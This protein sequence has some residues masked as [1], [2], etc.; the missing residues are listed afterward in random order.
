MRGQPAANSCAINA[1]CELWCWGSNEY[2]QLG[3][4]KGPPSA[5]PLHV[6]WPTP[7]KLAAGGFDFMCAIGDD[8]LVRCIGRA[9]CAQTGQGKSNAP[10]P[11]AKLVPL[12]TKA[13][14][15]DANMGEV[16]AAL[17]DGSMW[18]W[19]GA[20]CAING[21]QL[22]ARA[23]TPMIVIPLS[24]DKVVDVALGTGRV[25]V[26]RSSGKVACA[27]GFD[28]LY[29]EDVL[30]DDAEEYASGDYHQ[31][32]VRPGGTV[33][34]RG[35]N[36][37]GQVGDGTQQDQPDWQT[38]VTAGNVPL[39]SAT[40]ASAGFRGSC[41]VAAGGLLCW[42]D[43]GT[44]GTT[45]WTAQPVDLAGHKAKDVR[46]LWGHTCVLLDDDSVACAGSNYDL[47]SGHQGSGD[48]TFHPIPI[49]Q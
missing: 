47:E 15:I 11:S 42:G 27:G 34:C 46:V 1:K 22:P 32:Q 40:R 23:A 14:A 4:A 39:A 7:V 33:Q 5:A 13:V 6:P 28:L 9:D 36:A 17:D 18:C 48:W 45:W 8:G 37:S 31:C 3:G 20:D 41:A 25:C 49:P 12:P 19:G 44:Q 10:D 16:C 30:A 35:A 26:T 2:G 43:P 21:A 29:D 24:G 38:V